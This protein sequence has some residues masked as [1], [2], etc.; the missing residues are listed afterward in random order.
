M[1]ERYVVTGVQLG[2]LIALKD[3][4]TRQRTVDMIIENQ[5][6]GHSENPVNKDAERLLAEKPQARC[7]CQCS[8]CA[9]NEKH[10]W[11]ESRPRCM[12]PQEPS[13]LDLKDRVI[14]AAKKLNPWCIVSHGHVPTGW[15]E[16]KERLAEYEAQK[17]AK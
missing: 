4:D 17:G 10:D 16:F 2:M 11:C 5:F 1:S 3:Q 9:V 8:E 13:L 15:D 12:K 14:E 7:N 6:I